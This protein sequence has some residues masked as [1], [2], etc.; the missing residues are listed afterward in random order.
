[1]LSPWMVIS[2]YRRAK[3]R[4]FFLDHEGTL[5]PSSRCTTRLSDQS[6]VEAQPLDSDENG[7]ED[8][9]PEGASLNDGLTAAG[10]Q[11][12][13]L[14]LDCLEKLSQDPNNIVVI[15][16]GRAKDSLEK[17][18][19]CVKNIGLCAEHGFYYKLP[20]VLE[21]NRYE[22]DDVATPKKWHCLS[23]AVDFTWKHIALQLMNQYS[24]RTQGSYV[25]NKG[26]ALVFQ[27][28]DADPDFGQWQAKD[29]SAHLSD[30][31][32][33]FPV[34]VVTGKGYVEVR[35]KDVNKGTAVRQLLSVAEDVFDEAVD[36]ILSIGDDRS[37][38]DMF[39]AINE[40]SSS[41]DS[42]RSSGLPA[43]S[44][45]PNKAAIFNTS[46]MAH[47]EMFSPHRRWAPQAPRLSGADLDAFFTVT[48]QKKPTTAKYFIHEPE[49]VLQLLQG[50]TAL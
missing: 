45:I 7:L 13:S 16:S 40:L 33:D 43:E 23:E 39:G 21:P 3:R 20:S 37:D 15:L 34:A 32:F 50:I 19:G 49:E 6:W 44:A 1:M 48:I 42:E 31:L 36:F 12:S 9:L 35:L 14:V 30:M 2:A 47:N 28:R 24:N 27:Y 22:N 10:T 26:S 17:W 29:L 46:Q 5:V 11:P 25:E 18:F 41:T 4:A 8:E 38:E